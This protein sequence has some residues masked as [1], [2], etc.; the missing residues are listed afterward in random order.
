[1]NNTSVDSYLEDGCG[2]CDLYQ[3][4]QCKVHTWARELVALRALVNATELDETMK[5]GTPCYTL[6]GK[7]VVMVS[8]FNGWCGLSFFKG[9]LL[10][11]PDG[12]LDVPGPATHAGRVLKI[13]G[14][15]EL[16]AR[17]TAAQGFVRQ[18][19]ELERAGAEVPKRTTDEPM[20]D[21]LIAV[22]DGNPAV[23]E[24]WD[25]LTPGRKRSFV[26]HV[27]SAKQAKTR[28]ARSEKCIP[29]I[30]AGKGFNEY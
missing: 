25:A 4:P 11:D 19:I 5:W 16:E 24:A 12:L 1:M 22:L 18:A 6:D 28:V 29:K 20:P 2:R 27:G 10:D 23:A 14:P 21:E 3:T 9:V 30:L 8:A 26:L 7:N 15:D 17:R 13:T